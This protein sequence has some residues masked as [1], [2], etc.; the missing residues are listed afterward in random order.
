MGRRKGHCKKGGNFGFNN[1]PPGDLYLNDDLLVV[2]F[3]LVGWTCYLLSCLTFLVQFYEFFSLY[4][5]Q[6]PI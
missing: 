4:E 1:K 2:L 5:L 3:I 6:N